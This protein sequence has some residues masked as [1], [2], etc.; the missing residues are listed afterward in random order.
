M[1]VIMWKLEQ[2]PSSCEGEELNT[3]DFPPYPVQWKL[4]TKSRNSCKTYCI[5][6]SCHY[7]QLH[8]MLGTGP[9]KDNGNSIHVSLPLCGGIKTRKAQTCSWP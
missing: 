5:A 7:D 9:H 1:L 8:G 6:N 2:N 3:Q 4:P